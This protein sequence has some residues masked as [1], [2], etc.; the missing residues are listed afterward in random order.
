MS[1]NNESEIRSKNT[2]S[3]IAVIA[4]LI[5]V[6]AIIMG[7]LNFQTI[8]HNASDNKTQISHLQLLQQQVNKLHKTQHSELLYLV[9]L[10]N[11]QLV[12]GR[13]Q[14]A[15]LK[16]LQ[17]ALKQVPP[18]QVAVSNLLNSDI[19]TLQTAAVIDKNGIFTEIAA[20]NQA[21]AQLSAIPV[22]SLVMPDKTAVA[23]DSKSWR[24]YVIDFFKSLKN[25]FIIRHVTEPVTPL[26]N[27]QLEFAIK[28]NIYL[29]LSL[30]QW[31]LLHGE[32]AVYQTSLQAAVNSV[33]KYFS[34]TEDTKPILEKLTA[35]QKI[36]VHPTFP[37][38]N[39]TLVMLSQMDLASS[40]D[41]VQP[42]KTPIMINKTRNA[43]SEKQQHA[44]GMEN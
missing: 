10:A 33:S 23:K 2:S 29:Q 14:N 26:L 12:I 7:V 18:T 38:L 30:S 34:L 3:V 37:S 17:F 43:A 31:A 32:N 27:T 44:T 4:I 36:N 9:H 20:L 6:A 1:T 22:Q 8:S 40:P 11:M 41:L 28:Q 16:T 19:A 39:S 25:L 35:L 5:A 42:E 24:E 13:D 15:A 21:I